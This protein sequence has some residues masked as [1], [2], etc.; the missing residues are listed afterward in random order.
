MQKYDWSS[1]DKKDYFRAERTGEKITVETPHQKKSL[2][3]KSSFAWHQQPEFALKYFST[4]DPSSTFRFHGIDPRGSFDL[5]EVLAEK[6]EKNEGLWKIAVKPASW[7]YQRLV[8]A[9][10]WTDSQTGELC[11]A[12]VNIIAESIVGPFLPIDS[13]ERSQKN[14]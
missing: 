14:R 3:L 9:D 11:K 1:P 7:L 10:A 6:T 8:S 12:K 13:L 5:V 2:S 4:K